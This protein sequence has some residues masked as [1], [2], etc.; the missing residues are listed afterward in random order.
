MSK[1]CRLTLLFLALVGLWALLPVPWTHAG[2]GVWTTQVTTPLHPQSLAINLETPGTVYALGGPTA[3]ISRDGGSE[4][5]VAD[6]LPAG[7]TQLV[8]DPL[9]PSIQYAI[10]D[11]RLLKQTDTSPWTVVAPGVLQEASSV[12]INPDNPNQLWVNTRSGLFRSDDG[13]TAWT[14]SR[15]PVTAAVDAWALGQPDS[16]QVYAAVGGQGFFHSEDGGQSWVKTG[17]GLERAGRVFTIQVDGARPKTLYIASDGGI[18]RS[19]ENGSNWTAVTPTGK[20]LWAPILVW[21]TADGG[22]LFAAADGF[23]HR[24]KDGGASWESL[25]PPNFQQPELLMA[26]P[27]TP[28]VLYE[29]TNGTV[30]KSFDDGANWAAPLVGGQP[31]IVAAHP[32]AANVL[33]ANGSNS[34][35]GGPWRSSDGG[36]SWKLMGGWPENVPMGTLHFDINH[37]DRIL[38]GAGNALLLSTDGGQSWLPTGMPT[39]GTPLSI[40]TVPGNNNLILVSLGQIIL[41]SEDGGT[42]WASSQLPTGGQARALWISETDP[43]TVLVATDSGLLRSTDGGATWQLADAPQGVW[44]GL[45][46]GKDREVYGLTNAG[47]FFSPDGGQTWN[48]RVSSIGPNL[49]YALAK[50][51]WI[52]HSMLYAVQNNQIWISPNRGEY[53]APLGQPLPFKVQSLVID[54]SA[55][56]HLYAGDASGYNSWRYVLTAIPP[57]PTPT[58][59]PTVTATPRPTATRTP[60][61]TATATATPRPQ[62]KMIVATPPTP[63][64]NTAQGHAAPAQRATS[65]IVFVVGGLLVVALIGVIWF[66]FG[67]RRTNPVTPAAMPP[68]T[69]GRVFCPRCGQPNSGTSNFCMSCGEP[70]QP[71]R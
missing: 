21:T 15:L 14:G 16:K 63:R 6:D 52:D 1:S 43:Q 55:Q 50:P 71:P 36:Q 29:L 30:R 18:F 47:L 13:G 40:A 2:E 49:A 53:W 69:G 59:T 17:A 31:F 35:R 9:T 46:S 39:T 11:N 68:P 3:L 42:A 54:G 66:V 27:Q 70:L 26:D 67:R 48:Q 64:P 28:T 20:P 38:A 45:W 37:P 58:P 22:T 33:F 60:T 19:T 4:W 10:A 34:Y 24:S 12:K 32:S 57:P 65:P 51:D 5:A 23:L 44:R 62:A 8:F 41:R 7:T 61:L 25:Q 56:R